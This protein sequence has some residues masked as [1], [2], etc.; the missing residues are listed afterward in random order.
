MIGEHQKPRLSLILV[1]AILAGVGLLAQPTQPMTP[2]QT[3]ADPADTRSTPRVLAD[4]NPSGSSEAT[5][6][7]RIGRFVYFRANDG[8][9]GFEL[10]RTDGTTEG[11]TLVADVNPGEG[12]SAPE[13]MKSFERRIYFAATGADTGRE[14]WATDGTAEGTSL[15]RDINP[16]TADAL[17][18]AFVRFADALYFRAQDAATGLEL[19]KT[20]GTAETTVLV[21]DVH[22]GTEGSIPTYPTVFRGVLYLSADDSFTPGIGFDREL[23]RTDGTANGTSRVKDIN[24]GPPPSIPG[25]IMRFG[26]MLI[27]KAGTA[28]HGGELWKS[29]GTE[30]GTTIVADMNSGPPSSFPT[31]LTRVR[32]HIYFAA[33]DGETGRE[34]WRTN[35]TAEGTT[36]VTD[37]NPGPANAS[38]I[39]VPFRGGYL[40][41][42]DDAAHG[43]ELWFSD[44]TP[45]GTRL[46]KDVNPGPALSGP[47]DLTVV[48]RQAWFA[49]VVQSDTGDGTVRSELWRTD[50]TEAGTKR[51]W[52]APGRFNGYTIRGL[53]TIGRAL[54]FTAPTQADANGMATDFEPHILP[55]VNRE[56]GDESESDGETNTFDETDGEPS[57]DRAIESPTAV[58]ETGLPLSRSTD[59]Q[60]SKR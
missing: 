15:V 42:A 52:Q 12:S 4:I 45:A 26:Q 43:R 59:R 39:G 14:L 9:R 25:E 8:S 33:N 5:G 47:L 41:A 29:D 44:G 6:F 1:G 23:W 19:W 13:G 32:R 48:G 20:Q 49:T 21:A 10:W 24:P 16:G 58:D 18:A 30:A 37:I 51:V 40:F 54:L 34:L 7:T 38:P 2:V 28:E 55:L 11:T 27:F 17:P 56:S 50:G 3:Q 31:N 46:V 57:E 35:G 36:R 53:M 60:T 22:P